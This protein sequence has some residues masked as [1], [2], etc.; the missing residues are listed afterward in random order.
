MFPG[1]VRFFLKNYSFN[2]LTVN[3]ILNNFTEH[4]LLKTS[5]YNILSAVIF[6]SQNVKILSTIKKIKK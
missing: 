3:I 6:L 5:K 4:I 1:R 2:F